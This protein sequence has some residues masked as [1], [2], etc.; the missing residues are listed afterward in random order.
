MVSKA[1]DRD[2]KHMLSPKVFGADGGCLWKGVEVEGVIFDDEAVAVSL[3]EGPTEIIQQPKITGRESDFIGLAEDDEIRVNGETFEVKNW[4][5]DGTGEIVIF[6]E[7][8]D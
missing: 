4:M 1:F 5:P 6:L 2:F 3:G 7:R 8:T